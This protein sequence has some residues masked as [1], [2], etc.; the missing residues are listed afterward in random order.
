MKDG[1]T[2]GYKK[3]SEL[4]SVT[5]C[6][7]RTIYHSFLESQG[8]TI[9]AEANNILNDVGSASSTSS[10]NQS[11]SPSVCRGKRTSRTISFDESSEQIDTTVKG[12]DEEEQED[13]SFKV[14]Q[15]ERK[16]VA[17][18]LRKSSK[19]SNESRDS[20]M[21]TEPCKGKLTEHPDSPASL[22]PFMSQKSVA[23]HKQVK[24]VLKSIPLG[25]EN[26]DI[27]LDLE[28]QGYP[29]LVVHRMHR[30]GETALGMSLVILNPGKY[31]RYQ[32]YG[33]VAANCHAQPR[34]IKFLVPHWTKDYNGNRESGDKPS[35]CNCG[36][37]HTANYGGCPVAPKPKT[38]KQNKFSK[39]QPTDKPIRKDQFP[40]L[41]QGIRQPA[42][43]VINLNTR[44]A[45]GNNLRPAPLPP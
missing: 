14:I 24:A 41:K 23:D 30:R 44:S 43:A 35:C 4:C 38:F 19:S 39:Q 11:S 37:D 21:D 22:V 7:A 17:R 2:P 27:K 15:R 16:I 45:S 10:R 29:V 9:P 32:L 3:S 25:F 42:R 8:Y 20:D 40:P 26:E 13:L 28:R 12:S 31:H 1:E 18:R 34:C 36:K 5:H 6:R 33:H